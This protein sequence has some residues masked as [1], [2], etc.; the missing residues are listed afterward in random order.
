MRIL[1]VEDD[2]M[3]GKAVKSAIESVY[4]VIDWVTDLDSCQTALKT[5]NFDLILLDINL[6]DGSGLDILKNLRSKKKS[7]AV[8]ILTA[9]DSVINKVEGLD[10]GAD[11]Y[12]IKPFDLDELFAR[13]RSVA[14]RI[15][16]NNASSTISYNDIILNS[17]AHTVFKAGKKI[18]LSPKEFCIFEAL[19]KNS[20]KVISRARLEE[21]LYSW[22]NSVES[23]AVEVHI[24]HLRKKLGQNII[25]TTRGIGYIIERQQ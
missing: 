23:N 17:A 11:D 1:L 13:M 22:D 2:Q 6:P 3:L 8:I 21:S 15:A 4:D 16:G 14:R 5:T 9:R 7:T 18:D 10:L 19:L 12:L 24:H 25:K 20:G